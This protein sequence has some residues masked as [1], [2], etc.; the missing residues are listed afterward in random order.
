MRLFEKSHDGGENSGVT[1]YF[2]IELKALFSIVLI[3]FEKGSREA[4][5]NHAF[6]AITFWL[7]G[8]VLEKHL[9]GRELVWKAGQVKW[10]PRECFHKVE[11]QKTAWALCIRGPWQKQWNEV[12][13][14]RFI[15]LENGRKEISNNPT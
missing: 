13:K 9:D 2:L 15:T 12:R 6:D 10:T 1:G 8:S 7:K 3:K 5:H 14:D 11:V 4:F